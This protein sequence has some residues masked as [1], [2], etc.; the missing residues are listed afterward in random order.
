VNVVCKEISPVGENG[1]SSSAS[2]Y[3]SGKLTM[4]WELGRRCKT[5]EKGAIASQ[6]EYN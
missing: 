2:V 1:T 4:P 6:G 5:K 3:L